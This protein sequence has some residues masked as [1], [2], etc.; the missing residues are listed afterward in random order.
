[1]R[2]KKKECPI[3]HIYRKGYIGK[4]GCWYCS[5]KK[6]RNEERKKRL[7]VKYTDLFRIRK[8][9]D[10]VMSD[11]IL[12]HN[13]DF[14]PMVKKMCS[15]SNK[16]VWIIQPDHS[17]KIIRLLLLL[18]AILKPNCNVHEYNF[19]INDYIDAFSKEKFELERTTTLFFGGYVTLLFRKKGS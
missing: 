3:C 15:L 11:G 13:I 12:E 8:K 10:L 17:T 6:K 9:Y 1:M 19:T 16:Y 4:R 7:N 14:K 18:E 2:K 5:K